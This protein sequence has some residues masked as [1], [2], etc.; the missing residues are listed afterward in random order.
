MLTGSYQPLLVLISL[1]VA[2]VASYTALDMAARMACSRGVARSWWL[3]G[4]AFAMGV[5]IWSMHFVGMLAFTLPIPLGY[6]FSLTL[7]SLLIAIAVSWFALEQINHAELPTLRLTRGAILMGLGICGMHYTG[8]A[9]MRMMPAI[10]WDPAWF[11][12]S[13]AIAIAAA[14]AALWIAF[15][16]KFEAP[17]VRLWRAGA[18][19]IMGLA[20]VGM[21][22]TGMGA[23]NFPLG[24]VCTA[25]IGG[26]NPDLLTV[27][28]VVT[29]AAVLGIALSISVLDASMASRTALL[30]DSLAKA[31]AELTLLALHDNLTK[32][33]NRILLED[34]LNQAEKKAER[35]DS[36]YAVLFADL[37][38]FK[39]VNDSLGHHIG[40]L[41]LIEV[42]M[43]LAD[44]LRP[45]DTLARIGGDEFVVVAEGMEE[46]ASVAELC[47]R[48]VMAVGQP[49]R[50][51]LHDI[52]VSASIGVA[53]HPLDGE[54]GRTL[55]TNADAAMYAAKQ[56]GRNGFRF[57][58]SSMNHNV[59]DQLLLQNELHQAIAREEFRLHYQPK[60]DA[61]SGRMLGVEALIRWYSPTRGTVAPMAFIGLAEKN[62]LIVPI[63]A[64]VLNAACAQMRAWL[65][66]GYVDWKVAVNL[67]PVQFRH[68]LLVDMVRDTL[69][70]HGVPATCL[71][72]EITET[73]AMDDAEASL[74]QLE[75]LAD[76]GVS[77]SIDDFGTG[78]SSLA[79][80]KRLPAKEL[81]IDRSFVADLAPHTDDAAIVGAII[82]LAR[83]LGLTVVAEGVETQAQRE[84]LA[85]LGCDALQGFHLGKPMP[86][87]ELGGATNTPADHYQ[88]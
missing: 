71:T 63:G 4:G 14:G 76:M 59:R 46:A 27:L 3:A 56:S 70:R 54:D 47:E 68:P 31:N 17:R 22:Y 41:L 82:A 79:Y 83:A 19:G 13:V 48:L 23:A 21:H 7:L 2:I 84:F 77:L 72:L 53:L 5:G 60:F 24:S 6:D 73:T 67:S 8:M 85:H 80:L 42:A 32:L 55:L 81:K 65:D 30:A 86:A 35:G 34:R 1:L 40:D 39:A 28:V 12:A 78:Y 52:R 25:A 9:A 26:L 15:R 10:R 61:V 57:F 58:E 38:G 20:I 75:A 62:G 16:L 64:W 43:R 66:L 44:S 69:A 11:T 37:D 36:H 88:I 33:P 18:A 50:I 29:S 49:Y 45:Q 87:N 74:R 51:G